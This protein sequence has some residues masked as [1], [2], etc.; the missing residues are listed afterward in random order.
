M[1]QERN[2][3]FDD[4]PETKLEIDKNKLP[5]TDKEEEESPD[6]RSNRIGNEALNQRLWEIRIGLNV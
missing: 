3:N 2:Q 5:R 1:Q 6:E 4:Q